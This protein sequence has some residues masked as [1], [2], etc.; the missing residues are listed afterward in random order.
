MNRLMIQTRSREGSL[1][2]PVP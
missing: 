1:E 2:D